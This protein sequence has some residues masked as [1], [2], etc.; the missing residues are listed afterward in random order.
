MCLHQKLT[1]CH[2]DSRFE[3]QELFTKG[4]CC[5]RQFTSKVCLKKANYIF[6]K[7]IMN[8]DSFKLIKLTFALRVKR[9]PLIWKTNYGM[10]LM[11]KK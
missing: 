8:L 11:P 2:F 10:H 9:Q 1:L 6:H 4:F 7:E 5:L 3:K